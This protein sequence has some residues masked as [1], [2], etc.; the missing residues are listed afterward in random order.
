MLGRRLR[1]AAEREKAPKVHKNPE[2]VSSTQESE[3]AHERES[4]PPLTLG[5]SI[6]RRGG[7][8]K[9]SPAPLASIRFTIRSSGRRMRP[10]NIMGWAIPPTV[11]P[12]LLWFD[13]YN[14]P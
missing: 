5:S 3:N 4:E 13:W 10:I 14:K 1:Q 6:Y 12:Q 7:R 8:W 9:F 11:A 2:R